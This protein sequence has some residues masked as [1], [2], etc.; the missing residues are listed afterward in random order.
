MNSFVLM[1]RLKDYTIDYITMGISVFVWNQRFKQIES[2][3]L[4]E[5]DVMRESEI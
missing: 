2:E 5:T 4:G 3:A 1:A